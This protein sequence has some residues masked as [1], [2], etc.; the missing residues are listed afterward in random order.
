[1]VEVAWE[2]RFNACEGA[3][4]REQLDVKGQQLRP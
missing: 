2:V 3:R 4:L 1:M